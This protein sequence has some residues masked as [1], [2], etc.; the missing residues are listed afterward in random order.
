MQETIIKIENRTANGALRSVDVARIKNCLLNHGLV[1]LPSDTCYSLAGLA[2]SRQ[3]PK[4]INQIL[5]RNDEPISLAF[6]NFKMVEEYAS[7]NI[8]TANLLETFT[9]GPI[10]VICEANK[11]I[12]QKLASE[13]TRSKDYT[14]GVRIPDS[15][16]EREIANCT[17]Y[18]ITTVAIRNNKKVPLKNFVKA[19][20]IVKRGIQAIDETIS[21]IAIEGDE[22]FSESISTVA[23]YNKIKKKIEIIRSGSISKDEITS[24]NSKYPIWGI[25]DWT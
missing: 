24:I 12:S 16:I 2:V 1:I 14:L 19:I 18:P 9:P 4:K 20:E 11:D 8:F 5:K 21:L 23:K 3:L 13:V 17:K 22:K 25:E 10:T 15:F 7:L 6:P